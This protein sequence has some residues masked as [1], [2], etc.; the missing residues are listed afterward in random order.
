MMASFG[1]RAAA[2]RT[3]GQMRDETGD[4]HKCLVCGQYFDTFSSL[5]K[6]IGVR[7]HTKD[8]DALKRLRIEFIE[9]RLALDGVTTIEQAQRMFDKDEPRAMTSTERSTWVFYAVQLAWLVKLS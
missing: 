3:L 6:H 5:R 7:K 4:V 1:S 8:R 9:D 2:R